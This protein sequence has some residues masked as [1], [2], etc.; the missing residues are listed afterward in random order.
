MKRIAQILFF[1]VWLAA[2]L[3]D[4]FHGWNGQWDF[5][6]VGLPAG[7]LYSCLEGRVWEMNRSA[8][9]LLFLVWL[10]VFLWAIFQG[11]HTRWFAVIIGLSA[12]V[13]YTLFPRGIRRS[14][15]DAA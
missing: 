9:I 12:G 1:L 14:N 8:W 2:L 6:V 4:M 10:A 15:Q 7:I 3:W 11:W 5:I 13:L